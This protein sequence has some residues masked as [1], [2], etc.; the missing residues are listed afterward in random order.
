MKKGLIITLLFFAGCGGVGNIINMRL[1]DSISLV[2]EDV[3]YIYITS[4]ADRKWLLI[5]G[6]GKKIESGNLGCSPIKSMSFS[7]KFL[8]FCENEDELKVE[9]YTRETYRDSLKLIGEIEGMFTGSILWEDKICFSV[10]KDKKTKFYEIGEGIKELFFQEGICIPI[11]LSSFICDGVLY[12][13]KIEIPQ[14][15]VI[16]PDPIS[17]PMV[18]LDREIKLIKD[19]NFV[20]FLTI[21]SQPLSFLPFHDKIVFFDISGYARLIDRKSGEETSISCGSYPL[22]ATATSEERVYVLNEL[23]PSVTV[24]DLKVMKEIKTIW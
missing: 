11:S 24:L 3:D 4:R 18:S 23:N 8:I 1:P 21:K 14:G 7:Q 20:H 19:G 16:F 13:D 10:Y 15:G 12:P 6:E 5:T 2:R 9:I 17:G 22:S